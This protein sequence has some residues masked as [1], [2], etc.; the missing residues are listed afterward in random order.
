M[1]A[2]FGDMADCFVPTDDS[3][4]NRGFGFVTYHEKSVAEAAAKELDGHRV[5]G[6]RTVSY[7][8]LTLPTTP[9]V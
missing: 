8:H 5:N 9:Y 4:A 1:F 7:T 3:G 6:R 2:K